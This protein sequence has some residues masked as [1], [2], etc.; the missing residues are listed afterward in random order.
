[1]FEYPSDPDT[2]WSAGTPVAFRRGSVTLTVPLRGIGVG[3][4]YATNNLLPLHWLLNTCMAVSEA[5]ASQTSPDNALAMSTTTFESSGTWKV[6]EMF[7]VEIN[8]KMESAAVTDFLVGAPNTI[9]YSPATSVALTDTA[10]I[11][12]GSTFW[13]PLS[14]SGVVGSSVAIEMDGVGWQTIGYGGRV[15]AVSLVLDGHRAS[16]K[17]T[18]N[19]PFIADSHSSAA[20]TDPT[21][22]DGVIAYLGLNQPV[23]TATL[24]GLV[25]PAELS[26]NVLD[27]DSVTVDYTPNLVSKGTSRT[28]LGV[29]EQEVSHWTAKVG[30]TLADPV[31]TFNRDMDD[32][33]R[34]SLMIPFGPGSIGSGFAVYMPAAVPHLDASKR[35]RSG[36]I[37]QQDLEWG[38]GNW[39]GDTNPGIPGGTQSPQGSNF[40]FLLP[41]G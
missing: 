7:S 35:N 32:Q 29:T 10:I 6:G 5:T 15:S 23:Y 11:K 37:V 41:A 21:I 27:I 36:D 8:G 2:V 16:L 39:V 3:T 26:R 24:S 25:A 40:R 38:A 31:A 14:Q 13:A 17:L 33:V 19:F 22:A 30:M 12:R 20:L 9:V 18:V 1:M 34:R 28:A 4:A